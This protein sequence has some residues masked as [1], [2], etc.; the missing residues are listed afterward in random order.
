[1]GED[2]RCKQDRQFKCL[3][4]RR[5]LEEMAPDLFADIPVLEQRRVI[6]RSSGYA[7]EPGDLLIADIDVGGRVA[8]LRHGAVVA[9]RVCGDAFD[10]LAQQLKGGGYLRVVTHD[11][12]VLEL[13]ICATGG[14]PR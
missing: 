2:L 10:D 13:Q 9:G 3:G 5:F 11:D 12:D 1:M 4:D 14:P 6:A 7:T 8:E